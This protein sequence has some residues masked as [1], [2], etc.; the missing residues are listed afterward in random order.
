MFQT[1]GTSYL[2]AVNALVES[3]YL[4]KNGTAVSLSEQ[5]IWNCAAG[6]INAVLAYLIGG[7]PSSATVPLQTTKKTCNPTLPRPFKILSYTNGGNS[8]CANIISALQTAPVVVFVETTDWM[9]YQSGIVSTS[10]NGSS[11]RIYALLVGL[12]S[13]AWTLKG[14]FGTTDWG[15]AG[16]IRL[17]LGNTCCICT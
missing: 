5:H 11:L 8:S 7:V 13:D 17:A 4:I 3:A 9:T 16:F 1:S 6:S 15:E 10:C 14:S 2:F 12:S